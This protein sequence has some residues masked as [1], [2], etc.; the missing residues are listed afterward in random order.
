MKK[1]PALSSKD[2][3]IL[4]NKFDTPSTMANTRGFSLMDDFKK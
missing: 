4:E 3:T 1:H 2:G